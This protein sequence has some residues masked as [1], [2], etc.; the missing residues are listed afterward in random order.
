MTSK[1][2]SLILVILVLCILSLSSKALSR[3]IAHASEPYAYEMSLNKRLLGHKPHMIHHV[4]AQK[5]S[6]LIKLAYSPLGG[7]GNAWGSTA[8]VNH[9]IIQSISLKHNATPAQVALKWG[10]TKG[11]SVIVKSFSEERM[12]ENMGSFDLNLDDEDILE[13]EK[14]DEMKIMRG[15]FHVNQTTSPYKTIEELWDDEI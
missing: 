8:V 11:S 2:W 14:L 13:I 6:K 15:E 9:P 10:L 7:P 4:G 5:A 3:N 12:E 1:K